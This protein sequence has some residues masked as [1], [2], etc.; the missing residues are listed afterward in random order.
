M[1]Y[2]QTSKLKKVMINPMTTIRKIPLLVLSYIR[3]TGSK[4]N[5]YS[6]ALQWRFWKLWHWICILFCYTNK[7]HGTKSVN[8][9]RELGSSDRY[10]TLRVWKSWLLGMPKFFWLFISLIFLTCM[11][12]ITIKWH[13]PW[14][15]IIWTH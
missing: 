5:R 3:Q 4:G 10:K 11:P 14:Y 12:K 1:I 8:Y 7:V 13:L 9:I 2:S 6:F 15:S